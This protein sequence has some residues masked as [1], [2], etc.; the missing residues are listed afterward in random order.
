[1]HQLA[2]GVSCDELEI[3]ITTKTEASKE[4]RD[5]LISYLI[6]EVFYRSKRKN[7]F[8]C[9]LVLGNNHH[10]LPLLQL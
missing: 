7:Q 9:L 1:M 5:M 8:N 10:L 6:D 4:L 3:L 2:S